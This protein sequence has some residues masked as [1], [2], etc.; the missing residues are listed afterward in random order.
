MAGL[1]WWGL[2]LIVGGLIIG[3]FGGPLAGPVAYVGWI[4]LA[5]G[6]I[7]AVLHFVGGNRRIA[8]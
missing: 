1:I 7:L 4:L 2:V 6:L 8:S 3:L 5:V